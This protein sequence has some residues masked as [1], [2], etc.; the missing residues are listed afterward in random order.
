MARTPLSDPCV[1]RENR[2]RQPEEVQNL[3]MRQPG[4]EL[5][6]EGQKRPGGQSRPGVSRPS[7][8]QYEAGQCRQH[9]ANDH[10]NVV[11]EH[12]RRTTPPEG[13]PD[14]SGDQQGF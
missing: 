14:N 10:Q 9:Q 8:H 3:K 13:R 7:C 5:R 12:R 4:E 1:E 11:R 6:V 2:E